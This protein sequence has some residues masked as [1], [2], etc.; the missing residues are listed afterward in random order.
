MPAYHPLAPGGNMFSAS[1]T[2][3]WIASAPTAGTPPDDAN[4]SNLTTSVE[5]EA[6]TMEIDA[7]SNSTTETSSIRNMADHHHHLP[8]YRLGLIPLTILVFY[9]VSG[10]PFGIEAAVRAGGNRMALL[11]FLIGPLVWSL[12]EV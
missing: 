9:N 2:K 12:Q 4:D 3:V 10:G 1:R 8:S 5:E 11:G 7:R 6:K